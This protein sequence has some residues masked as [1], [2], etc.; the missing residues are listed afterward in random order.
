MAGVAAAS[1]ALPGPCSAPPPLPA[2]ELMQLSFITSASH[3]CRIVT[4]HFLTAVLDSFCMRPAR[5]LVC[6]CRLGAAYMND[7]EAVTKKAGVAQIG[8]EDQSVIH[9]DSSSVLVGGVA[10]QPNSMT[11]IT[12]TICYDSKMAF[13]A[14][15]CGHPFCN[16]CYATFVKHK[17]EDEG[18]ESFY[19]RCPE[20]KCQLVV[21]ERLVKSLLPLG[22]AL[23]RY[24]NAADLARSYVD[25]QPMLKW[26]PAADC[27]FA[28]RG[29]AGLLSA[30]CA[31]KHRFCFQCMHEDHQPASCDSLSK[32]LVKCRDDSE[33]YN[34]LVANTKACPKCQTSIEKNGGCNRKSQ[35]MALRLSTAS[36]GSVSRPC[37]LPDRAR[38]RTCFHSSYIHVARC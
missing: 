17:I 30:Q 7:P 22:E 10:R 20:P 31:C 38:Y 16:E 32:W 35:P 12:C 9:L 19:M 14:L 23:T 8:S 11:P 26:C 27:T 5:A 37:S 6:R 2:H 1:V 36:K 4:W 18:H 28:V 29:K 25:D 33:T 3:P 13:S 24:D 34:W 21:S 15:Q